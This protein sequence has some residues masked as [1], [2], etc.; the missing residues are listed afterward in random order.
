MSPLMSLAHIAVAIGVPAAW[1]TRQAEAGNV[2]FVAVGRRKLGDVQTIKESLMKPKALKPDTET[3]APAVDA[4]RDYTLASDPAYSAALENQNL[5]ISRQRELQTHLGEMERLPRSHA[6][7]AS[8]AV[9]SLVVGLEATPIVGPLY[10]GE[11]SKRTRT[12]LATVEAA[13]PL[14]R[15]IVDRLHREASRR[16]CL[17]AAPEHGAILLAVV[18][19]AQA[20]QEAVNIEARFRAKLINNSVEL[21]SPLT[22]DVVLPPMVACAWEQSTYLSRFLEKARERGLI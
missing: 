5:L 11:E 21:L 3:T 16:V 17:A 20:L 8:E 18:N 12:E 19:A 15:Q 1:L 9:A 7:V 4:P 6:G 13:I 14:Q 10:D 22:T 2:P